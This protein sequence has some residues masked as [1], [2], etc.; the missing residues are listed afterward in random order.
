VALVLAVLA[1]LAAVRAVA[2]LGASNPRRAFAAPHRLGA[3]AAGT[4]L[5]LAVLLRIPPSGAALVRAGSPLRLAEATPSWSA[6]LGPELEP[7]S[8][9]LDTTLGNA[10]ELPAGTPVATLTLRGSDRP[11]GVWTLQVGED[12]GE[13]AAG[14][15][16]LA[17]DP[18]MAPA[19]PPWLS[20]VSA[21]RSFFGQTYRT[22]LPVEGSRADP[23]EGGHRL[24]IRR[25]PDL[26]PEVVL[27]VFRLEVRR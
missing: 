1:L 25:R 7:G 22:V 13:W 10:G 12:T 8:I 6:R 15:P 24:E 5:V 9:V 26:P 16:E 11:P 27:T 23:G 19:P 17:A 2:A 3:G 4:L 14:R 21:E 20:W 18:A